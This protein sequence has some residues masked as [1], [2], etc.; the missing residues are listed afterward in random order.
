MPVSLHCPSGHRLTVSRRY[1]GKLVRCPKC[2]EKIRIPSL[3]TIDQKLQEQ[4]E[5]V[6]GAAAA[7]SPGAIEPAVARAP[8]EAP[9]GL[10]E[11]KR[12]P[13]KKGRPSPARPP[14][15]PV[16][17]PPRTEESPLIAAGAPPTIA[18]PPPAPQ[19]APVFESIADAESP[20][21]T[22]PPTEFA[23]PPVESPPRE[24]PLAAEANAPVALSALPSVAPSWETGEEA[25]SE[26]RVRGYWPERERRW[27]CL[28]LGVALALI[29]VF[30]AVPAVMEIAEYARSDGMIPI[31]RWAWLALLAA[32]VQ[33][34]YAVYAAQLPDWSTAWVVTLAGAALATFYAFLLGLTFV[35]GDSSIVSLLELNDQAPQGKAARWCFAMLGIL[36]VYAYFAGR[37]A[38]RWRHAFVL[39]RPMKEGRPPVV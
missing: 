7:S 4:R 22:L 11:A 33:I 10:S 34:G 5:G 31:A 12:S 37:S 39:T 23:A 38:L 13:P 27:T 20:A 29:G 21:V 24:L 19:T 15:P 2:G 8:S 18:P 14:L 1:A 25:P 30:G 28:S 16:S 17:L 6:A 26:K 35:A 3:E 36:G 32:A 9:S